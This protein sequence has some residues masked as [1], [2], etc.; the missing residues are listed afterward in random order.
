MMRE[1]R[2]KQRVAEDWR[3]RSS[4]AVPVARR[5]DREARSTTL[6][7]DRSQNRYIP[8]GSPTYVLG[9]SSHFGVIV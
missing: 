8:R 4:V 3:R 2:A 1:T 6:P 5:F 7:I 9:A